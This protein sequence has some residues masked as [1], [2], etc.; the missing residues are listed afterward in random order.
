LLSEL[1]GSDAAKVLARHSLVQLLGMGPE[2]LIRFGV[3]AESARL[4]GIV[5]QLANLYGR[6]LPEAKS[7]IGIDDL[8]TGLRR[9]GIAVYSLA[10]DNE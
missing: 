1:L 8:V 2:E 3:A 4:L 5:G 10:D 7:D 9:V 6:A